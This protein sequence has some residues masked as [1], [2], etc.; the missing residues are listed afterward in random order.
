MNQCFRFDQFAYQ[1]LC[2]HCSDD[3]LDTEGEEFYDEDVDDD[4][5]DQDGEKTAEDYEDDEDQTAD[6]NEDEIDGM[7]GID[8]DDDTAG[9]GGS[10]ICR[11]PRVRDL[12]RS[13]RIRRRLCTL[14]R[15]C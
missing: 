7:D 9:S 3:G 6:G 12:C 5:N 2:H 8:E 14:I 4:D 10:L 13:P 1:Y 11:F 15:R